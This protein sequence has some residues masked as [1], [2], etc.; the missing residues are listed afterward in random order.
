MAL[1]GDDL[2]GGPFRRLYDGGDRQG[3]LLALGL[4]AAMV[5]FNQLLLILC[6]VLVHLAL[7]GPHIGDARLFVKAT[8]VGMFPASLLTALVAWKFAGLRG[9]DPRRVLALRWPRFGGLGWIVFLVAFIVV[10]YAVIAALVGLLG[11]D[12]SQYTPGP[13]G[14]SPETGSTG[15]VK[16]AMFDLADEPRLFALAFPSVALGAPLAEEL[17]FRGALFSALAGQDWASAAPSS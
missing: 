11:I 15:E 4:A 8:L 2:R 3:V 7:Y 6:G 5:A 1:L 12:L 17:I 14:Q 9:A 10:M 16:E 13:N